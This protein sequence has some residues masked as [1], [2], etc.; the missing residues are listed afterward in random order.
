MNHD[1]SKSSMIGLAV[2]FMVLPLVFMALRAWAKIIGKRF[3]LDD[4][5][6][7]GALVSRNATRMVPANRF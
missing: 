7:T 5:L 1:Y 4:Y 2:A 3:A 6:A